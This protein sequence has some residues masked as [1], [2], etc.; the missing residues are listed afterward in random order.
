MPSSDARIAVVMITY[1]RCPETL[2]TLECLRALPER[3]HII[4]VDNG[5]SD[6]TVAAISQRFPEVQ[7][8]AAGENLGAA[9]RTL[10]V[11]LTSAPYVAL[12]DDDSW[13]RAGD[14]AKAAD[15][16]DAHPRL[17]ALMARVL[18][19]PQALED[20]ICAEL[21]HSPLPRTP[22]M[23]G[24]ALL[25]FLASAAVVRRSAFLQ[26]GG[27][28]PSASIGGEEELLAADLASEGW[29]V[30]YAP[31]LLV[32]HYPSPHRDL[33]KRR[34]H[35]VRNAL[36]FAWL[37]RPLP[38]ALAQTLKAA[39]RLPQDAAYRRGLA[40]ALAD[41]RRIWRQR[42]VVPADVEQ[43]LRLLERS[44]GKP[45]SSSTTQDEDERSR[46]VGEP[47]A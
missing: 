24:P 25:G 21:E 8:V 6:D 18:V 22:D 9:G 33:A 32:Y 35:E 39:T 12:C 34:A 46:R 36:W 47:A 14:L 15:L 29:W 41:W 23:P 28:P 17:G 31:Q 27:F 19:G 26:V 4:V 37:R 13:W 45:V 44:K 40:L 38:R 5:S 43:A 30:C 11:Q 16:F 3:P 7:L 1:N 20:P 2:R 42:R 10:G